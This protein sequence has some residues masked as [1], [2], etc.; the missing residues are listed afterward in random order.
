MNEQQFLKTLGLIWSH[1]NVIFRFSMQFR[2]YRV[3]I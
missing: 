1:E 2:I 3:V